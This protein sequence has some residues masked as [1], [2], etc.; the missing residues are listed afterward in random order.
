MSNTD[1]V[2]ERTLLNRNER[3]YYYNQPSGLEEMCKAQI[4]RV[5]SDPAILVKAESHELPDRFVETYDDSY[6]DG[7]RSISYNSGQ[8]DMVEAGWVK[9][10]P[11]GVKQN[12]TL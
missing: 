7:Q 3:I 10:E 4:K 11:K 12:D 2:R 1:K 8:Q 6:T 5:L 9:V